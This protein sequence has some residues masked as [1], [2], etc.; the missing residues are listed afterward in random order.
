MADDFFIPTINRRIVLLILKIT[1]RML[2]T[3]SKGRFCSV[4]EFQIIEGK[5]IGCGSFGTVKLAR[6]RNTCR[7]YAVKIVIIKPYRSTLRIFLL[8]L[9]SN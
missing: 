3:Q 7:I 9:K 8:R 5:K 1:Y 6:H 4:K 2:T